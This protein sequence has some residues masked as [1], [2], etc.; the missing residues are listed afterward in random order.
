MHRVPAIAGAILRTL[1]GALMVCSGACG[2]LWY[3][4]Y[5]LHRDGKLV[6][7]RSVVLSVFGSYEAKRAIEAR[8]K[9]EFPDIFKDGV[10]P[11]VTVLECKVSAWKPPI[12]LFWA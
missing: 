4:R 8:V 2:M 5:T 11:A 1:T 12:G 10:E 6:C 9:A 7:E 3:Y